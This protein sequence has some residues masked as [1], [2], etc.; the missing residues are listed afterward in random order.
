MGKHRR[1]RERQDGVMARVARLQELIRQEV[2]LVL[3]NEIRD[4][5]LA[6]VS[7]T[8]VEL[9]ADGSRA[10]LWYSANDDREEV[11]EGAKGLLRSRIAEG[12]GLKR[13]PEIRFRRDPATRTFG[14]ALTMEKE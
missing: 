7:I 12:L 2:N 8:M 4:G 6:G 13:T 10:R 5:R 11:L 9:A 3:R 1:P 14:E